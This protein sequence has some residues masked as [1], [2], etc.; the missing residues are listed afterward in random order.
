MHAVLS[1]CFEAPASL[2]YYLMD[3]ASLVTWKVDFE[4]ETNRSMRRIFIRDSRDA[5]L[6]RLA[7]GNWTV[8]EE[9][10][11]PREVFTRL[12]QKGNQRE[13]SRIDI[14]MNP[15]FLFA[16]ASVGTDI[17]RLCLNQ[18][19]FFTYQSMQISPV[20]RT[21]DHFRRVDP[22]FLVVP[23]L[24]LFTTRSYALQSRVVQISQLLQGHLYTVDLVLKEKLCKIF[25]L[26]LV[27]GCVCLLAY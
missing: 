5:F 6:F 19:V 23:L 8:V 16:R 2:G 24:Q 27:G 10:V 13:K 7:M 3:S 18:G 26:N 4:S 9:V 20:I 15:A 17:R 1:G 14:C 12:N 22:N 25:C 11:N 21:S